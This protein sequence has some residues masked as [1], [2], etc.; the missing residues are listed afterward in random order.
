MIG[1]DLFESRKAVNQNGSLYVCIPVDAVGDLEIED[2]DRLYF[3][4]SEGDEHLTLSGDAEKL[5][6]ADSPRSSS[7]EVATDGGRHDEDE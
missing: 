7:R 4:A 3:S 2:G 5:V 1:E 6:L